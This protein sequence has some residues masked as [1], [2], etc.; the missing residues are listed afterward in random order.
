MAKVRHHGDSFVVNITPPS[1]AGEFPGVMVVRRQ[2]LRER[3]AI[4]MEKKA[5]LMDGLPDPPSQRQLDSLAKKIGLAVLDG[6]PQTH[7]WIA[8]GGSSGRP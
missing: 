1:K 6:S 3:N 7:Q 2:Q 5:L 8:K 4:A